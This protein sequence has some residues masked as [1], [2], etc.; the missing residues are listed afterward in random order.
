MTHFIQHLIDMDWE[1]QA[2]PIEGNWL[3]VDTIADLEW[4]QSEIDS[5]TDQEHLSWISN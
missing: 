5:G 4:Y 1:V 2:V 3:E